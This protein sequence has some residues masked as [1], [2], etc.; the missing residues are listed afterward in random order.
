MT[1]NLLAFTACFVVFA[2]SCTCGN[3]TGQNCTTDNEC[4]PGKCIAN[5]CSGGSGGGAGGNGGGSGGG[6]GTIVTGCNPN[7]TDNGTRDT[8]CD[9]ITDAEEYTKS[10]PGNNKTDPCNSDSDGDGIKDGVE[11][12]KVNSPAPTCQ[13]T[14]KPDADPNTSSDPTRN[15]T[16]GDGLVD[17]DEDKNKDGKVD[18]GESSPVKIDSDCDG[19]GDKAEIDNSQGCVLD[20]LKKDSDGDGLPDGV[21]VGLAPPGADALCM[22][23]GEV[24][25]ADAATKT[26]PC[27][28]DSDG[29]QIPD[30]AE[31]SNAN[32]RV[33]PGELNPADP[34]DATGPAQAVCTVGNLKPINFHKNQVADA[35]IALVPSFAEIQVLNDGAGDRGII[36]YDAT[37]QLA[38][39]II[40][41]TPQGADGVAEE[42]F[43]RARLSSMA[44]ATISAPLTQSFTTWDGFPGTVRATYDQTGTVDLKTRVNDMAQAYLGANMTGALTGTSV[45]GGGTPNFKIQAEY[46]WRTATRAIVAVVVSTGTNYPANIFNMDDVGGGSAVAQAPDY[47]APQCEVFLSTN[48]SIVDF[49]WVVDNSGSMGAYQAAV[50]NAG[51]AFGT[52]LANAGIDW[53]V[54]A[55]TTDYYNT[56]SAATFRDFTNNVT[57]MQSWFAA[58]GAVPPRFGTSGSGLE[59]GL[60]SAQQYI[61]ALLPKTNVNAANKIRVGAALHLIFLGDAD[62]QSGTAG[63]AYTTFLANYDGAGSRAVMH[64]I[65]CPQGQTCGEAQANPRKNL[66][67]IAASGGVTGDINVAQAGSAQLT[68]TIDAILAAAIAGTG[69]QLLRPPLSATI[70]VAIEANGTVGACNVN[71]VPRSRTNGFDFDSASRRIVFYGSCIP[72]GAGKKVAVSYKYWL[73]GSPDPNGCSCPAPKVCGA[74][75]A[76]VCPTNC[77]GV[78]QAGTS[79]DLASCTCGPG[80]N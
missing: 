25:D 4:F 65:V 7:A 73:D 35:Q 10:Y 76:C 70:K 46:V 23:G 47:S 11:A 58:A 61:Q 62:D 8:D 3:N 41:K 56:V 26:N 67:V 55:V 48:S 21:E 80:I 17:G 43:G 42:T 69:H 72:N 64:G 20:P 74:G 32:G 78:C 29:D 63:P 30:G 45:N 6:G 14:F 79:C 75:G 36:F 77:G 28:P 57:T 34:A 27:N 54:A 53:R 66:A 18:P 19:I 38:G 40:S 15:D 22:Y 51:T 31:D 2:A 12:G 37:N 49:V 44:N 1:R 24:F 71:D 52:R 5:K 33:D 13:A 59:N 16:D 9:G 39:F 50:G 60:Q 68:A